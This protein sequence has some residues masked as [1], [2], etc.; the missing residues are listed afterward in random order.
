MTPRP[1]TRQVVQPARALTVDLSR[2]PK[3][4]PTSSPTRTTGPRLTLEKSLLR[5][6]RCRTIKVVERKM[7]GRTSTARLRAT[8]TALLSLV[9]VSLASCNQQPDGPV[10]AILSDPASYDEQMISLSGTV[11]N[12]DVESPNEG[13]P[14]TP[15]SWTMDQPG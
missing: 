2:P 13:T 4:H 12:L 14:T 8:V 5:A 3:P 15:S 11:T 10:K 9:V 7:G 1:V 6:Y